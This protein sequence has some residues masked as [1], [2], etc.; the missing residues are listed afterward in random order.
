MFVCATLPASPTYEKLISVINMS[1]SKM[2]KLETRSDVH[3]HHPRTSAGA[4]PQIQGQPG[5]T[6][7]LDSLGYR[8]RILPQ[9]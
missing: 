7:F 5:Y 3:T 9:K 6:A 1:C 8:V 4:L 2:I